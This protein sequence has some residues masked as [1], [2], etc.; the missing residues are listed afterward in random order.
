M[1]KLSCDP[2]VEKKTTSGRMLCVCYIISTTG[3]FRGGSSPLH[4]VQGSAPRFFF[5]DP[6]LGGGPTYVFVHGFCT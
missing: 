2:C 4:G 3:C 5:L 6:I 1:N